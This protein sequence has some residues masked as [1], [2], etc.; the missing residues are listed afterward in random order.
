MKKKK[1]KFRKKEK[2][3]LSASHTLSNV[4]ASGA[5]RRPPVSG[6]RIGEGGSSGK[7]TAA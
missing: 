3:D 1:K 4:P 5:T 7:D 6:R 2:D